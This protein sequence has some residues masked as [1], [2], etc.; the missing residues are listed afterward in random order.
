MIP[1]IAANIE[2]ASTAA[3]DMS[4]ASRIKG[5][6]SIVTLFE[7]RSNAEFKSSRLTTSPT[8]S[9]KIAQ[10][11]ASTPANQA[12]RATARAATL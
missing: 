12:S 1:T 11:R 10:L 9:N 7:R 5:S 3:A 4:L 8:Q 6:C 2:A